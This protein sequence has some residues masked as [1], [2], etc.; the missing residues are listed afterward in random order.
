MAG[1]LILLRHS[2]W[3]VHYLTIANGSCGT[4]EQARDEIVR[5]RR[6]EAQ[7]AA[8]SI[9]AIYHESLVDDLTIFYAVDLLARVAALMRKVAPDVVLT[10]APVDYMEDHQNTARLAVTAAFARGMPNFPTDPPRAPTGQ[11]L[12]LYHAQPHGNRDLLRQRVYP[13]LYVDITQ[14]IEQKK[15]M[16]AHHQSQKVWLDRTQGMDA[17]LETMLALSREVGDMSG[18][19]VYA[20]GW[21]RRLHLGLGAE[22]DDPLSVAL[23]GQTHSC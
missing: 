6:A 18:R 17:Y 2:G 22:E 1:T 12:T 7:A 3:E 9:G 19:F 11:P 10:H 20:E 23:Q 4:A 16:L 5:V 15:T 13:D 14:V 8:E 21:R